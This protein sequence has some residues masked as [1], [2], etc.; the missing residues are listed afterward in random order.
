MPCTRVPLDFAHPATPLRIGGSSAARNPRNPDAG[1]SEG[2]GCVKWI[3][4]AAVRRGSSASP[5]AQAALHVNNLLLF[6]ANT[7]T[8]YLLTSL[9]TYFKVNSALHPSRSL[10]QVPASAGVRAG[11]SPLPGG[12]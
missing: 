1:R 11:M 10:N 6:P 12:R 7:A 5:S 4:R 3:K 9:T 8:T 2:R